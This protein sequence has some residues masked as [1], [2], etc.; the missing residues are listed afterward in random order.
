[1]NAA[2]GFRDAVFGG[3]NESGGPPTAPPLPPPPPGGA[4][5]QPSIDFTRSNKKTGGRAGLLS[6]IQKGVSLKSRKNSTAS[7]SG[8]PEPSFE[9]ELA[10]RVKSNRGK[11]TKAF[12]R[13]SPEVKK[14]K[15]E[16][17]ELE[18]QLEN[19]PFASLKTRIR[20]QIAE[21]EDELA[22]IQRA[23]RTRDDGL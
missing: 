18:D 12:K 23:E 16:I 5:Q 14:L 11:G 15:R 20:E 17:M 7:A 3:S 10:T 8:A 13:E 1:M 2:A 19:A 21:K 4:V 22:D 9:A 6:E